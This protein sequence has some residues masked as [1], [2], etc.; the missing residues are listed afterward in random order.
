MKVVQRPYNRPRR[1]ADV[2]VVEPGRRTRPFSAPAG[3]RVGVTMSSESD[4]AAEWDALASALN[5]YGVNHV[6][7]SQR[8]DAPRP[9]PADLFRRLALAASVRLQEAAIPLLLTHPRLAAA[10]QTGIEGLRGPIRDRAMRRYAAAAALQRMWRT[11]LA[12]D[13]GLQPLIAPAY[14]DELGLPALD[15]DFGRATLRTLA[16]QE[17]ELYGHDA[18]AGYTSLMDLFLAEVQLRGWGRARA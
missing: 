14:L 17:E 10:A 12:T 16:A 1:D 18:W 5:A 9:P 8:V 11:R 7:P 2:L 15:R 3:R 6:A 4:A 13:L